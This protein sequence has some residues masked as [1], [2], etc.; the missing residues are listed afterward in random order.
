M[1][2]ASKSIIFCI[3]LLLISACT[4]TPYT[5]P[6]AENA[7]ANAQLDAS[8]PRASF[9]YDKKVLLRHLALTGVRIRYEK[10]CVVLIIPENAYFKPN[11]IVLNLN[12]M[13]ILD[14]VAAYMD[15]IRCTHAIIKGNTDGDS[16]NKAQQAL[17]ER[18]A[19]AM[20][21]YL[22]SQAIPVYRFETYRYGVPNR[23][24]EIWIIQ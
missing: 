2:G 1:P 13:G 16:F 19:H 12:M 17:A 6:L 9:T 15:A 24:I 4:K 11:S 7:P 8:I 22:E 20:I 3:F 18:R 21:A 5:N 10:K 14:Y 23:S